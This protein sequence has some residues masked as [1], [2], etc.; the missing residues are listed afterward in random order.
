VAVVGSVE[1]H[2]FAGLTGGHK[3]L[4]IGIM[5]VSEIARN[6]RNA[7]SD[8]ARPFRL[9]GNPVFDDFHPIAEESIGLA[10]GGRVLAVQHCAERW[11]AGDPFTTLRTLGDAARARWLHRVPRPLDF[12][13]AHV[14]PPLS[15]SLYQAEKAVKHAEFAVRDGGIIVLVAECEDGVGP[16]RF[17][18]MMAQAPDSASMLAAIDRDGYRLG[19]HKAVRLRR[20]LERGVRLA[21][22]SSS[23]DP[24]KAAVAGFKVIP[25][26]ETIW[27]ALTGD[28]AVVEDG[29][30]CVLEVAP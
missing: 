14:E 25:D 15:R 6:H 8:A 28:G 3:A 9:D 24:A 13:I 30:H 22:V 29:A 16:A 26:L 20:L 7:M 21:V 2:W 17:V 4:T 11:V 5:P 23:F 12:V 18:D 27:R 1:P 19:D 10:S